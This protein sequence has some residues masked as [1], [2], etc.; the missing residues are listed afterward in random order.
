MDLDSIVL[1]KL[2]FLSGVIKTAGSESP[3]IAMIVLDRHDRC[4]CAD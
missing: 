4:S 1:V 3:W 2:V